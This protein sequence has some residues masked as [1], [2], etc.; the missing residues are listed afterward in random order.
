MDRKHNP[1]AYNI[2]KK[3]I[4]KRT[5]GNCNIKDK[6]GNTLSTEQEIMQ[7]WAEYVENLYDDTYRPLKIGCEVLQYN[8]VHIDR[9]VKSIIESL[10]KGKATCTLY[11]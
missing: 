7:R 5:S 1:K 8:M 11:R 2:I 4:N 3:L 10:P 6:N 9:E